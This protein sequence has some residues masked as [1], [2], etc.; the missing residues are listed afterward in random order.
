MNT[1]GFK[2]TRRDLLRLAV[3]TGG[4]TLIGTRPA[5]GQFCAA[6]PPQPHH[7]IEH[8]F[9]AGP[10]ESAMPTSPLILNPFTD[11]L[12]V[13][14]ALAPSDP[15]TWTVRRGASPFPGPNNQDSYGRS[16]QIWPTQL[17]LP[18]PIFYRIKLEVAEHRITNQKVQPID[19]GGDLVLAPGQSKPGPLILPAS[20]IYGFNGVFPGPMIN[21]EYGRPVSVRFENWLDENPLNLNRNDF[22]SPDWAFLTHLH[23]G[24]T[25]PESDGNPH[26]MTLNDGGYIPGDWAD[27]LY[28]M[29][30]PDND[31]AE[32]Q[33][34]LWFHDH[35]KHHT[36]ANVYKGMVGLMPFYDPD[37]DPGDETNERG[38]RLPGRR[39]NNPDGSFDVKYDIPMALYDAALDDGVTPHQ[40]FHNGCG[41]LHP[42]WWG[43]T[44]YRHYNNR[45]F[46]GDIFTINGKAYPVLHVKRRKYRFRFLDASIARIYNLMLMSSTEGPVAAKDTGRTG[47][48]LQ[49]QY[50]LPD[51]QQCMRFTQIASEGGLL[52]FPIVRDSFEIWPA[53]R[54]EFIVDFTQYLDGSP[55]SIGDEIYLVNTL[56]MTDGRKPNGPII[57]HDEDGDGLPASHPDPEYDADYSV[58]MLK[59]IIDGDPP[60]PD[61]SVMPTMDRM[62]RAMPRL[63]ENLDDLPHRTF[64][65]H[66]GGKLGVENQWLINDLIYD[67][68]TSLALPKKGSAEVWTLENGGGGWVHPMHM[69]QEEHRTLSRNGQPAPDERH[70][71]DT[72]KEDTTAL[73]EGES[74][75]IFRRFRTFTGRYVAHCHNLAHEDHNMMFGWEIVP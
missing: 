8:E 52:P 65:L 34:F 51:G 50:Q 62:L 61:L 14:K 45:G 55:V 31:P 47:R 67:S 36:G 60:E 37:L 43:Q 75:V 72:G 24:H 11:E 56:Q 10:A 7:F 18:E 48:Q 68:K 3:L 32:K 53:K 22:G 20:T 12:P 69:H 54:R 70:P 13:P 35:R 38:L 4:A 33:S 5:F 41:E 15:R 16:H 1:R 28:L 46:V 40:D 42:E 49:G 19:A 27:N 58:P 23:N 17:G 21:A 64:R 57:T 25:A 63:P 39:T 2:L 44:F 74:V 6:E 66:R 71:D 59:I 30:P 29:Y 9:G 26:Y 73:D